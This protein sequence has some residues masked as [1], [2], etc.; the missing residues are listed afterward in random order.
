MSMVLDVE[1]VFRNGI[2]KKGWEGSS[3][4]NMKVEVPLPC[5]SLP[6][7]TP[8]HCHTNNNIYQ[9]SA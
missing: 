9:N 3:E 4:C 1:T 7:H 5:H 2:L 6:S 8:Y